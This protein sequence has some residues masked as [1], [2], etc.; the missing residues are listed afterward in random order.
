MTIRIALVG[1]GKIAR[2]QHLPAILKNDNFEMAAVVNHGD[3][4]DVPYPAFKTVGDMLAAMPGQIDAVAICTP[5]APRFAIAVEIIAAGIPVLLEK[6]PTATLGELDD[7]IQLANAQG[8]PLFAV[9]HSQYSAG[10]ERAAEA[11]TNE[12]VARISM[13]WREDVR[14]YH[15]G[16]EWI[17]RAGGFGVFDPGINGL[18]ILTRIIHEPLLVRDATLNFPG[19]RQA[20][21]S[22]ELNFHGEDNKAVM[23]W[24]GRG[25]EEWSV[26]VETRSGKSVHLKHGGAELIIDGVAQNLEPHD[27]YRAIYREFAKIVS[28]RRSNVDRE[29]LR[30]VADSFL[31]ATRKMVEDFV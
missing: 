12:D 26:S 17:W 22:A 20:P 31:I 25:D 4:P 27:E 23:D 16:Q 15:A 29:P 19:N 10:V 7:L 1:F 21:V 18:S 3:L 6:P 5:P 9:W 8:C 24:S 13:V 28:T 30:I 14:K 2:D 11:L